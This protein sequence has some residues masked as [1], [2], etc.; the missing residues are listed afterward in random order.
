[1]SVGL[2][3]TFGVVLLLVLIF[4]RVPIALALAASGLLGYAMLDGWPKALKMIGLVPYQLA[5]GYSLSVIPLFILMGAV[6]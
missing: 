1:M 4:L 5:S 3:T 6:A 2:I